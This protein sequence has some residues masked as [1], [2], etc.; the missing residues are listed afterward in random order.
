[1]KRSH[2]D[3]EFRKL[4]WRENGHFTYFNSSFKSLSMEFKF[5][6]LKVRKREHLK[7]F[8]QDLP[9][10]QW[11]NLRE[12]EEIGRGSFGSV[13]SFFFLQS[14]PERTRMMAV[15]IWLS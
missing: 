1:M 4:F 13:F 11:E 12:K 2:V 6:S 3:S 5:P 10:F 15:E 14:I 8:F 9:S 7:P